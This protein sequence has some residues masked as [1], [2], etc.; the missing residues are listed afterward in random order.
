MAR[1]N[2]VDRAGRSSHGRSIGDGLASGAGGGRVGLDAEVG[3]AGALMGLVLEAL[4]DA[5]VLVDGSGRICLANTAAGS[6]FGY[7]HGELVG[8][9]VEVLI[10]DRY[11]GRHA[12]HLASFFA[13]PHTRP[14]GA[15]PELS[16]V[17]KDGV[18]FPVDISIGPLRTADGNFAIA[19]I[20]D[21]SARRLFEEDVRTASG[22]ESS[23][24]RLRVVGGELTQ[25]LS[26]QEA[27]RRT[28]E[29]AN[30]QKTESLTLLETLE[31]SSPVGYGFVDRNFRVRRMNATLAATSGRPREELIGKKVSEIMPEL[32]PQLEPIFAQVRDSGEPVTNVVLQGEAPATPGQVLDW[33]GNYY[34]VRVGGQIIGIGIVVIDVTERR[35]AEELRAVVLDTMVEGVYVTDAQGCLILMNKAATKIT[36]WTEEELRGRSVHDAIH[37]QHADGSRYP[38]DECELAKARLAGRSLRAAQDTFTRKDGTM[39]PV[40][41]SSVPLSSGSPGR[42]DVVVFRDTTEENAERT[43]A[44]RELNALSWVGRIQDALDDDRMVLYSQAIVPLATTA[45]ASKELLIRMRG[46]DGELIPPGSFISIAERFGQIREIDRW[47][48]A[49]AAKLAAGGEHLHLNLSADSLGDIDLSSYMERELSKAG[50]DPT[51]IVV[52][53]TETALMA[54]IEDGEAFVRSVRDIGC[55]VALDDFG[56]GFGSFT[57]LQKLPIDYLKIDIEFIRDLAS[58]KPNQ[59]LIQ[60]TVEI[61]QGFGLKTIAEGVEDVETLDLLRDYGVDLAQGF[62]LGRPEP[63]PPFASVQRLPQ[64]TTPKP[65]SPSATRGPMPSRRP[66]APV[67]RSADSPTK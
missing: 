4:P 58:N 5:I 48:I 39:V 28:L 54:H 65:A 44:Q 43:R 64:A 24:E 56:T 35:R 66:R 2:P 1:T 17:R 55:A 16:G 14:L 21:I 10:P 23:R 29:E 41:Y 38:K 59:H 22:D 50:A 15:S 42:G 57:Y 52:E 18:E 13:S 45:G 3:G 25:A 26:D 6:M 36:G 46:R 34:P 31:A 60:A 63:V 19:A 27:I 62:Y 49:Q 30:K 11:S 40:A 12:A 53:I 20:R 33:L 61:A 37:F 67:R 7:G 32:W 9:R 47:V 8:R 51:N